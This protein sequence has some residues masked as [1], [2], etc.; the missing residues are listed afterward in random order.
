M[1]KSNN[2]FDI[3]Y[4]NK[5]LQIENIVTKVNA[6]MSKNKNKVYLLDKKSYKEHK[7]RNRNK[8]GQRTHL[9]RLS[10]IKCT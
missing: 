7:K 9:T 8:S 5:K 10:Y 1:Y 2:K 4:L 3:L 6:P